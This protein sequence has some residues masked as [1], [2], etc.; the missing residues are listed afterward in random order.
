LVERL[1][2]Q[3]ARVRCLARS[4]SSRQWLKDQ[5]LEILTGDLIAPSGLEAAV[6]GVDVVFHLAGVTRAPNPDGYRRGNLIATRNLL[7][8]LDNH[9][10]EDARFIYLSSQAAAGPCQDEP[11]VTELDEPRPVSEY[12]RSKLA[13]EQE[14]LARAGWRPVTVIRPPSVYGPRDCDFLKMFSAVKKG[15]LPLTGCKPMR[16]SIVHVDDL[17]E[18]VLRAAG[19]PRAAGQVYFMAHPRS[20]SWREIGQAMAKALDRKVLVLPTPLPLVWAIAQ[21]SGLLAP[22]LKQTP[23][24]NRD[25]WWEA[26]EPG[27]ICSSQKAENELGFSPAVDMEAGMAATAAWYV[28]AG[29]L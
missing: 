29:W 19:S 9:G 25:K 21:V 22:M 6:S 5:R 12:G 15:L 7:E 18:G 24:L 3:G 16:L 8:A 14:V 2:A 20:V 1:L 11:G 27:W 26:R 28:R 13:A 23:L 10:R 4:G 17:V